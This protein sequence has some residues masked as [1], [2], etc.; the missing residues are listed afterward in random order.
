MLNTVSDLADWLLLT[1]EQLDLYVDKNGWREMHPMPGVSN[2][3]YWASPIS[4]GGLRLISA[5]KPSLKSLQRL[6]NHRILTHVS[7]H[8]NSFGFVRGRNCIGAA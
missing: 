1:P 4:N 6:I 7:A 3:L 5:P 8:P 2:Y